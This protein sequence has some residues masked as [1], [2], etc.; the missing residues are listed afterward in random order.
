LYLNNDTILWESLFYEKSCTR[1]SLPTYEF[2]TSSHW[3]DEKIINR[4]KVEYLYSDLN[5]SDFYCQRFKK[6]FSSNDTIISQHRVMGKPTL[7]GAYFLSMAI[8]A[9]A[10]ASHSISNEISIEQINY[11][12]PLFFD[13]ENSSVIITLD[14]VAS[15]RCLFTVFSE[16]ND[17]IIYCEGIV[18]RKEFQPLL[19]SNNSITNRCENISAE[20]LY[21]FLKNKGTDYGSDFQLINY[22]GKDNGIIYASIKNKH[23]SDYETNTDPFIIDACLHVVA[24]DFINDDSEHILIPKSLKGFQKFHSLN[25]PNLEVRGEVIE[26]STSSINYKIEIIDADNKHVLAKIED[27]ELSQIKSLKDAAIIE[28]ELVFF[29]LNWTAKTLSLSNQNETQKTAV[30]SKQNFY[31]S[32]KNNFF[33]FMNT[34][35][36]SL[37]Y[38]N[39][40]ES[41]TFTYNNLLIYLN[42]FVSD[43][44]TLLLHELNAFLLEINKILKGRKIRIIFCYSNTQS[45]LKNLEFASLYGYIKSIHKE[46]PNIHLKLLNLPTEESGNASIIVKEFKEDYFSFN[47][48]YNLGI[49][50]VQKCH[51]IVGL[52]QNHEPSVLCD[53]GVYLI[54]GGS[55]KVGQIIA[56][57]IVTSV[58]NCTL[59]LLGHSALDATKQHMLSVLKECASSAEIIYKSCDVSSLSD[60]T[61]L[62][63]YVLKN[64]GK[65]NGIIHAAGRIN[66]NLLIH[67]KESDLNEVVQIKKQG[68]LLLDEIF[69]KENLDFFIAFSSIASITGNIGQTDYAYANAFLDQFMA[70]RKQNVTKGLRYGKSISIGWPL[71]TNGGMSTDDKF[72]DLF[73]TKM[74]LVKLDDDKGIEAFTTLLKASLNYALVVIGNKHLLKENL[75]SAQF[76][77][78]DSSPIKHSQE[79]DQ[80]AILQKLK[81]V[82]YSCLKI[83]SDKVKLNSSIDSLGINSI[84]MVQ[85]I[86]E[87]ENDFESLPQTIFYECRTIEELVTYLHENV[88]VKSTNTDEVQNSPIQSNNPS[89]FKNEKVYKKLLDTH[90]GNV[91]NEDIAIIG[92]AG[93]YPKSTNLN[94]FWEK[95][96]SGIDCIEEIPASRWNK[97][98]FFKEGR[99]KGKTYSKWGGFLKNGLHFDPLFFNLSPKEAESMDPQERLFLQ[100]AWHT[101]EDAGYANELINNKFQHHIGVFVG[102]M[103]ND[104]VLHNVPS[105]L[106]G[107]TNGY[108][109]TLASIANRV[110]YILDLKGPSMSVDTMCSSSLTSIKLAINSLHNGDCNMALAGGVNLLLHPSKY[111]MLANQHFLSEDGKCRS[112]GEGGT[113]YVPGEG[114]GCILL[115]KKSD[116]ILDND[117]IYGIIKA[118]EINHNGKTNGYT[119]PDPKSQSELIK[120]AVKKAGIE[121]GEIGYIEG[122][123]TGTSLGDPI[124]YKGLQ[125]A[126]DALLSENEK[127]DFECL[128][129]SVKSNI[130]HLESAAGIAGISKI[131]LQF[132]NQSIAPSLHSEPLNK[133]IN[134]SKGNFKVPQELNVISSK[135]KQIFAGISSF[136]AGGSN[137]F[138]ILQ[139][140]ENLYAQA[141]SLK[142]GYLILISANSEI[143]LKESISNFYNHVKRREGALNL[144][145]LSYTLCARRKHLNY[146][147]GFVV[148]H[149]DQLLQQLEEILLCTELISSPHIKFI[150]DNDLDTTEE[151][152]SVIEQA[153]SITG[154]IKKLW[155]NEQYKDLLTLWFKAIEIAWNDLYG[156]TYS[157]EKLP[158]YP[159][160]KINFPLPKISQERLNNAVVSSV[161]SYNFTEIFQEQNKWIVKVGFKDIQSIDN[162][163]VNGE[164]VLAASVQIE[165]FRDVIKN[166]YELSAYHFEEMKFLNRI[167][168][169]DADTLF[170]LLSQK[171]NKI[172]VELVKSV[173]NQ[174]V[175]A[176]TKCDIVSEPH[177][178]SKCDLSDIK[179]HNSISKNI[180]YE[181]FENS[182]ILFK[183]KFRSL[184]KISKTDNHQMIGFLESYTSEMDLPYVI[185]AGFQTLIG[186]NVQNSNKST[187]IPVGFS[188]LWFSDGIIQAKKVVVANFLIKG[189][190]VLCDIIYLDSEDI[191]VGECLG[192]TGVSLG[193]SN[194]VTNEVIIEEVEMSYEESNSKKAIYDF[195]K[196]MM[197]DYLKV[198]ASKISIDTHLENFGINSVMTIELTQLLEK[199]FG[200][201]PKP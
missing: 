110:S 82:F 91:V 90:L 69:R 121:A 115:K 156:R 178:Y 16:N 137:G 185:D 37:G 55:G 134:F 42:D 159:F 106:T 15:D 26:K 198:P 162:H 175:L 8:E 79:I 125:L 187:Y 146:R 120:R 143:S 28:N 122:H 189:S 114:V 194:K 57:E 139:K 5:I 153:N 81:R 83:E 176:C 88:T 98:D 29:D 30:W 197:V 56:K 103:N 22:V 68:I 33:D 174:S 86:S 104:F 171:K 54:V 63:D 141:P 142:G 7:P 43:E 116:A 64:S 130:G 52:N 3:L 100:T 157:I 133:R 148:N 170:I 184:K 84:A 9:Y 107:E 181:A 61:H 183:E 35:N 89:R 48:R 51:E 49:R 140:T 201:L 40:L 190:S 138:V 163:V 10:V 145:N 74:G 149:K 95:I 160:E 93:Q 87:L 169:E 188:K 113:G 165:I 180:I 151:F 32:L 96:A 31:N 155:K 166:F 45:S 80:D 109:S 161:G 39:E 36:S 71:W 94:E 199:R 154:T 1:L 19:Q 135:N 72:F 66:D 21:L 186:Y 14:A 177:P 124:E 102:S 62:R 59:Y 12:R 144:A 179:V 200:E 99:E 6:I 23:Y 136:G 129:G 112:Y 101:L 196:K 172:S 123:G 41:A 118:A 38:L 191:I 128:I 75:Q 150:N 34:S 60:V 182:S 53:G 192:L 168:L 195:L 167:S 70:A 76:N 193:E 119:V 2:D 126:F 18:M 117:H 73:G 105:I 132:E 158:L 77:N 85:I 24:A 131:L 46:Y 50:E 27:I 17:N 13:Q 11:I 25:V 67:K 47:V 111:N 97:S 173:K 65:I 147:M 152:T 44:Q 4:K 78:C 92:L 108:G 164:G 127:E 20:V 58:K